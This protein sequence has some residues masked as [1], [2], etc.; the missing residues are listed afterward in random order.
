MKIDVIIIIFML[1]RN[2]LMYIIFLSL[3]IVS[4]LQFY[5]KAVII[6]HYLLTE[7]LDLNNTKTRLFT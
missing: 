1:N 7:I 2:T 6:K 5:K 3:F 4:H